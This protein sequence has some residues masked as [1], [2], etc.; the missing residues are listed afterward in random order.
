M[1]SSRRDATDLLSESGLREDHL[2]LLAILATSE[3]VSRAECIGRIW[4]KFR[5]LANRIASGEEVDPGQKAI[6]QLKSDELNRICSELR[7]ALHDAAGVP[8]TAIHAGKGRNFR[9]SLRLDHSLVRVDYRLV[10]EGLIDRSTPTSEV[11]RLVR[12]DV[13]RGCD[14]PSLS[15]LRKE[16]RRTLTTLLRPICARQHQFREADLTSIVSE[17]IDYGQSPTYLRIFG[18]FY[19]PGRGT[20]GG[21]GGDFENDGFEVP[22]LRVESLTEVA[23]HTLEGMLKSWLSF[24]DQVRSRGPSSVVVEFPSSWSL[25][26]RLPVKLDVVVSE[27]MPQTVTVDD[28]DCLKVDLGEDQIETLKSAALASP[29][30]YVVL[31]VPTESEVLHD[32]IFD[33]AQEER[34]KWWIVDA[35]SYFRSAVSSGHPGALLFPVQNIWNLATCSILWSSKWVEAFYAPLRKPEVHAHSVLNRHINAVYTSEPNL[36]EIVESGWDAVLNELPQALADVEPEDSQLISL[37]VGLGVALQL[38]CGQLSNSEKTGVSQIRTYT[39]EALFGMTSMWLFS[40]GYH[41]WMR[42][43]SNEQLGGSLEH[44]QRFLPVPGGDPQLLPRIHRAAIWHVVLMYRIC[45]V[46]VRLIP[47][48]GLNSHADRAYFGKSIG[49]Y[50]WIKLE[51]DGVNWDIDQQTRDVRDD[52]HEF[53]ERAEHD[54]V[55]DRGFGEAEFAAVADLKQ[56]SLALPS[57]EPVWLFPPP[58]GFVDHPWLWPSQALG[59]SLKA[60]LTKARLSGHF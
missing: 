43:G 56:E 47:E 3:S 49:Q 13:L 32:R 50:H 28:H 9:G 29:N 8:R 31:A 55:L 18:G 5:A 24:Q 17:L 11:L 6:I 15:P 42:L 16:F 2:A 12:G 27:R 25:V 46:D 39:P 21:N 54:C 10:K 33:L 30:S 19:I 57:R 53:F 44:N 41:Q 34:F 51:S 14:H 7:T 20:G 4:P 26:P 38:I 60:K 35:Q 40:R 59:E 23:R 58:D 52:H 1:A 22:A 36:P 45:E 37:G 48:P